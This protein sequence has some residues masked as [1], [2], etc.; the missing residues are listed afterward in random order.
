MAVDLLRMPRRRG[1]F[2]AMPPERMDG[3]LENVPVTMPQGLFGRGP[4]EPIANEPTPDSPA[5]LGQVSPR[6]VEP[7]TFPAGSTL[8]DVADRSRLTLGQSLRQPFDYDA[9]MT[10]MAGDQSKPGAL[11]YIAAAIGDTLLA[12]NG[13]QPFASRTLAQASQDRSR[14]LAEAAEKISDWRY[15]DFARQNQ[16]D[17]DAAH[18]FTIGRDRV[19]Y[20]PGTGQANVLYDGAEDFELYAQKLGLEPG[21]DEYFRAVEDYVLRSSGPSAH[22]RDIELDDHRTA[23]DER[24]EGVRQSNRESMEGLRQGNRESMEGLRQRN[25]Q[26]NRT[27][28]TKGSAENPVKVKSPKEARRLPK[29]TVFQTPDGRVKV[30]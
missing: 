5:T 26:A 1:L 25:R 21:T 16:A 7:V 19:Q 11:R 29:G 18:P 8:G 2:G 17:L 9:A 23:N 27:S 14:R 30:R 6:P 22:G 3:T 28:R 24:L 20:N 13:V 12:N 10:R 15:K 4:A